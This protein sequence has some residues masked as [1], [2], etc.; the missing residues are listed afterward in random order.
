MGGLIWSMLKVKNV[1][2]AFGGLKALDGCT[3]HVK[4]GSIAAIIGPNGSGKSTLFDVISGILTHDSGSII[5]DGKE[6]SKTVDYNRAKLG[7]ARTFQD[8]RLFKNLTILD[9]ME[10]AHGKTDEL[11]LK[12]LFQ[13]EH[14]KKDEIK[15]ILALV[16]LDKPLN[17]CSHDLSYGQRKLLDLA[18]AIAKPHTILMLDEPVTGV[19]PHLR[20]EIKKIIIKLNKQGETIVLIEHDMNFVMDLTEYVYVMD[21]GKVIA[22]GVPKVIQNNKRVLDAYLGE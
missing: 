8:V 21:Y 7:I 9:H 15:E 17:T 19:N 11:L 14:Q 6:I 18:V 2:K 10:I 16:G 22:E 20:K 1:H 4:K 3:L 5:L 12:S 13:T